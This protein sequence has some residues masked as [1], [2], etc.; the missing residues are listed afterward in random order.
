MLTVNDLLKSGLGSVAKIAPTDTIHRALQLMV[1]NNSGLV[2]VTDEDCTVG[3]F[4]ET[5]FFQK[6]ILMGYSLLDTPIS[7][8]MTKNIITVRP[9]HM[10]DECLELMN[11]YQIHHLVVNEGDRLI[12]TVTKQEVMEKIISGNQDLI[13]RLEDYILGADYGR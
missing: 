7:E 6:T 2:V 3:I 9:D 10:L 4:T 8:I 13:E 1:E 11:H 12:A 5:D